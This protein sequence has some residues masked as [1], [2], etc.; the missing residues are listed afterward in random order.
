[1]TVS[2]RRKRGMKSR[3][4]KRGKGTK[5]MPVADS[6]GLPV[7]LS[8]ESASPHEVKLVDS[9]LVEMVIAE[10]PENLV[11]D[12]AY[13]SDKLDAQL[14]Q[15]GIELIAPTAPTVR[16]RPRTAAVCGATA[17]GGKLN[18]YSLGCGTFDDLSSGTSGMPR[19]S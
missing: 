17:D 16:T 4:T 18:G 2:L 12:K 5:I 9:T 6:H 8:I 19:I 3:K 15:Y 13:D 1:M 7:G 10:A 11:G 14:R